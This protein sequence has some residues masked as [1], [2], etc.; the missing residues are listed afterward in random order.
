[1]AVVA[2]NSASTGL[3]A[4]SSALDVIANN[5]ANV[6]TDG[7]KTSRTNFQDLLYMEKA[8]PG[9]ENA[10]GDQRPMGLYVG[11]GTRI[12]GTQFDFSQGSLRN[13]GR[14]L[15]LAIQG[16]GFFA[17]EV[18]DDLS[19]GGVAYTR[20]GNFTLNV[21]REIVLAN[22]S[23]RRLIPPIVVPDE[24]TGISVSTDGIVEATINGQAD[25]ENLGQIELARFVNPTGLRPLGENL[26]APS[27]ASGPGDL[28]EPQVGGRGGIQQSAIEGSNVDPVRELVDLIRT[29]RA[30]E[31]NSQT[32]QAADEALQTIGNLR[33]L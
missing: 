26:Y 25:P 32:I 13:T 20:A 27:A 9:V 23:G 6:N 19:E 10:N 1:M 33:R 15:D 2:L 29:Q 5:L 3:S 7:F 18:E 17:V 24:A 28:G 16:D 4:L 21:D 8:Q 12:S 31:M 30:F 14:E 22:S 11:L